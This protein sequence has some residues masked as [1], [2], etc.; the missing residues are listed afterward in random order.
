[1]YNTVRMPKTTVSVS[2]SPRNFPTT[3]S[4]RLTGLLSTVTTVQFSISVVI[5]CTAAK[6]ATSIPHSVAVAIARSFSILMSS[7]MLIVNLGN[8]PTMA[9]STTEPMMMTYVTGRWNDCRN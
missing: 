6:I 4:H 9:R 8:C 7:V 3:N 2:A 5:A 1:M